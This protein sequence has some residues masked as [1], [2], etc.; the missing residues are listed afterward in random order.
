MK[1]M[2]MKDDFVDQELDIEADLDNEVGSTGL[3]FNPNHLYITNTLL[4]PLYFLNSFSPNYGSRYVE[5]DVKQITDVNFDGMTFNDLREIVKRLV[6]GY[7]NRMCVDLYVDHHDYDVLDFL[8]EETSNPDLISESSDEYCFDDESEDIDGNIEEDPDGSQI[9]LRY[10]IKKGISYTKHDPTMDWDQME[11]VLGM[12]FDHPEQLKIC[13]A[14]YGV[15]NGYQ[16]WYAKN[17]WKSTLVF[18]G[19]NVTFRKSVATRSRK[20]GKGCSKDEGRSANNGEGCS[21]DVGG[22]GND[23]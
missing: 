2:M 7:E 18:C 10:K 6:H 8:L 19:R 12:M 3:T 17:D 13:L 20:Q 1:L 5:G 22:S 15:A 11:H 16:L 4:S 14:N 21:K 9:D 23:N